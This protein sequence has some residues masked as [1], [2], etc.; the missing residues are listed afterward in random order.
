MTD[1]NIDIMI[2]AQALNKAL[3]ER[4]SSC[5]D[6]DFTS[7]AVADILKQSHYD[8]G[9]ML[10]LHARTFGNYSVTPELLDS[11]AAASVDKTIGCE[12]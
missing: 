7:E 6:R 4:L 10:L 2:C 1:Q 12:P 11:Y 3:F 9:T 8:L 5:T